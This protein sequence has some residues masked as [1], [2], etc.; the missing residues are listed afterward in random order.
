MIAANVRVKFARAEQSQPDFLDW[1]VQVH[2]PY[3]KGIKCN[4]LEEVT[5]QF[6]P[7]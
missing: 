2:F 1:R 7:P 3:L 5:E 6:W 4:R